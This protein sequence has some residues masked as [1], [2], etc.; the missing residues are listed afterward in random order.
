MTSELTRFK[1]MLV[2]VATTGLLVFACAPVG[3]QERALFQSDPG[4]TRFAAAMAVVE[5]HCNGCHNGSAAHAFPS[6]EGGFLSA[7][8]DRVVA[9]DPV[10]SPFY[11]SIR[12]SGA[13]SGQTPF[14]EESMP[15]LR[16]PLTASQID[17]I[18]EWI[19]GISP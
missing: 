9:G 8:S 2:A 7:V 3:R 16:S 11:R 15:Q 6:T 17:I 19:V 13:R 5:T 4:N 1:Q 14:P 18:S 12:G 10:N